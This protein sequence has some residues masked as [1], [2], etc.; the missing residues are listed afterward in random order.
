MNGL[1]FFTNA[2]S[3]EP[4]ITTHGWP[5]ERTTGAAW[6]DWPSGLAAA[7][8]TTINAVRSTA[9]PAAAADP[10]RVERKS[11]DICLPFVPRSGRMV[12]RRGGATGNSRKRLPQQTVDC[13]A[14]DAVNPEFAGDPEPGIAGNVSEC[15]NAR[16]WPSP[17]PRPTPRS[18]AAPRSGTSP[19]SPASRSRRSPGY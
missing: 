17:T 15:L 4:V 7:T 1:K 9:A 16:S 13:Q 19:T 18:G 3:P 11:R 10:A 12:D 8:A 14:H 2:G 5:A 6:P